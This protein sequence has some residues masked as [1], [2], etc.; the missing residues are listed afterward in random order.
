MQRTPLVLLLIF[1]VCFAACSFSMDYAVVNASENTVTVTYTIA[2]T[3]IDPLV[4]T[5]IGVP[6]IL[7]VSEITGREWRPLSSTQ[8]NFDRSTRRVTVSLP[9]DQALLINRGSEWRS[10]SPEAN[11][12]IIR[13]VHIAGS[14]GEMTLQGDAVYKSFTAVPKPFFKFGP[15]T[16]A[17]ITYK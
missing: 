14:N 10:D 1:T 9:P 3:G 12:F 15:P 5:G 11:H 16:V 6:A 7:S 17:T 13:E 4:A 8:F 2:P